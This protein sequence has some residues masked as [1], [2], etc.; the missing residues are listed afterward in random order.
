VFF[1]HHSNID[2]IWQQWTNSANGKL[3]TVEDLKAY[4]W[5]Y[6]FFNPDGKKV[7]YSPEQ[8]IAL[9]YN[10][11]YEYDDTPTPN[12]DTMVAKK[13]RRYCYLQKEILILW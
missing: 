1:L 4:P 7:E 3:I 8:V 11:D 2:R 12:E 5:H 6:T 10:V 13:N 9:V